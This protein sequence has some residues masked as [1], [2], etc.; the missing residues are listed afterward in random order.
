MK[1]RESVFDV[2]VRESPIDGNGVFAKRAF[3]KGEII[4]VFSGFVPETYDPECD[5]SVEFEVEDENGDTWVYVIEPTAPFKYLN[6]A[7]D[8][9]VCIATPILTALRNIEAGEELT[10]DYG[11]EWHEG[12]VEPGTEDSISIPSDAR[13]SSGF[14]SE[15]AGS[16]QSGGSNLAERAPSWK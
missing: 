14:S 3:K 9:C 2:E 7:D 13:E 4:G 11:E 12:Y 1:T 16:E 15:D 8:A 5:Y 6:H 10:I